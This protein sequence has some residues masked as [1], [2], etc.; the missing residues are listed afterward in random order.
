M[1]HP[2]SNGTETRNTVRGIAGVSFSQAAMEHAC[3]LS[4]VWHA[5]TIGPSSSARYSAERR[6]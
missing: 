3:S 1:G 2:E 4:R 5:A 6:C